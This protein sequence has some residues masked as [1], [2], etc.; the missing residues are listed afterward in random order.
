M[1]LARCRSFL[2][3]ERL[4]FESCHIR[5]DLLNI[6]FLLNPG[7]LLH[8]GLM[9]ARGGEIAVVAWIAQQTMRMWVQIE[10]ALHRSIEE[11]TIVRHDEHASSKSDDERF[12]PAQR[13]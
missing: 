8:L 1:R 4:A 11:F 3:G 12:Q 13:V 2:D 5:R 7:R 6:F 9:L 10:N